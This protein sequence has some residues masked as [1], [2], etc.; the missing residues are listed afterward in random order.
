MN[1]SMMLVALSIPLYIDD[2]PVLFCGVITGQ[3]LAG[4]SFTLVSF[5]LDVGGKFAMSG[6][7]PTLEPKTDGPEG[8]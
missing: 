3:G 8:S 2:R 6:D 4:P 7:T 1:G 5:Y